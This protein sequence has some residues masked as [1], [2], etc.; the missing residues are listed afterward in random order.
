M[1]YKIAVIGAGSSYTPELFVNLA[2]YPDRLG[3]D[4]VSLH[5]ITGEKLELIHNV[6]QKLVGASGG[7]PT[8][9]ATT[10]L[11]EAINESDFIILQIRVGGLA[12]RVRDETL[13]MQLGMVGN[14][15]TGPGGFAC[16]L[17]TV[18]AVMEVSRQ[19]QQFAPKAWVMNLSNPAGMVTEAI[20]NNTAIPAVGFCNI[21]I[22]TTYAI[23]R[24][25]HVNPERIQLDSFGLNHLSWTRAAYVDEQ[26]ILAPAW[27]S[28]GSSESILY[29]SG[30]VEE[31]IQPEWLETLRMIPG[32]YLRYFYN[33]ELVL[34]QDRARSQ[35]RGSDDVQAE[36]RLK[37]IFESK[38]YTP[39]VRQ[40]LSNKGGAQYYLPVLQVIDSMIHDRGDIVVVDTLNGDSM[41][42][43][44]PEACVEVPS[45]IYHDRI[46]PLS[47]GPMPLTVRSLV[48]AV[49]TYEQL[50]IQAALA[51][52]HQAALAALMAHPLVGS[53]SKA[54]PFL[55]QML[56]NERD[57]LPQFSVPV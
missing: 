17:R 5:D 11:G 57:F 46:E 14:E 23:G 41:P 26:D 2:D 16:G 54:Q 4:R 19:I 53:L 30:L 51:G 38:G 24:L 1:G 15:T 13:P 20:L 48:Q 9:T 6:S 40:I 49:K 42:D 35:T 33:P 31:L 7:S 34:E 22:N 39:E 18:T 50:T 43:L 44:P 29:E 10:D 36:M 3:V 52:D 21:P 32:W 12:A 45:R 8:I 28:A 37:E 56:E 25:L 27:E 47:V 55:Q